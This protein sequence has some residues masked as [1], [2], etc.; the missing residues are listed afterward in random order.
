MLGYQLDDDSKS[1]HIGNGWES[2]NIYLKNG[3]FFGFQVPSFAMY[4]VIFSAKW[5]DFNLRHRWRSLTTTSKRV[6]FSL[7][8]PK[9]G[10]ELAELPGIDVM[11][12]TCTCLEPKCPL[13]WLE[14]GPS[15]GGLKPKNRGQTGSRCI[16]HVWRPRFFQTFDTRIVFIQAILLSRCVFLRQEVHS[17]KTNGWIPKMMALGQGSSL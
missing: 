16:R 13:F 15:F 6:T 17:R 9:K 1:L 11:F 10:H 2:P 12:S 8:I 4:Q 3:M 7:T 5:P 14:F